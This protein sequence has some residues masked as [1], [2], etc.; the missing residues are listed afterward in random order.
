MQSISEFNRPQ[1][2]FR[3]AYRYRYRRGATDVSSTL[4]NGAIV[5][6]EFRLRKSRDKRLSELQADAR[7]E[8]AM[9]IA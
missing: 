1:P 2:G 9:P 3:I 8:W 7:I 5:T 6:A 4:N